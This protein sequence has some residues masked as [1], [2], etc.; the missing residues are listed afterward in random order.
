[1]AAR[2]PRTIEAAATME[3]NGIQPVA[4]WMPSPHPSSL[5]PISSSLAKTKKLATFDPL[6]TKAPQGNGA[7][8]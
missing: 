5:K 6:A 4:V 7:P 2:L 8:W 1:M 3:T